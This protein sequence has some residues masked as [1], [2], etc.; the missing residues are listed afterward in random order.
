[1]KKI[2]NWVWFG[3][4]FCEYR[5]YRKMAGGKW[6]RTHI[7][8]PCYSLMWLKIPKDATTEYREGNWRGTPTFEF[9]A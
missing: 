4:F 3:V 1:M 8:E 2:L 5:W 9:Y 6:A 7:E